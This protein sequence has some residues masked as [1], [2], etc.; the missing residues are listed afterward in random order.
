MLRQN[1]FG[2]Q[3]QEYPDPSIRDGVLNDGQYV[4]YVYRLHKVEFARLYGKAIA[5]RGLSVEQFMGGDYMDEGG[6]FDISEAVDDDDD[7]VQILEHWFRQP[8]DG[9]EK[10]ESFPAGAVACSIQANGK[11]LRY[12]PNYWKRT[13]KQCRLFPFIHYWRVQDENSF[14][15]KSE[16]FP[17]LN[18]IDAADRKMALNELNEVMS[19]NDMVIVEEEALADGEVLTNEPGATVTV[20]PNKI[21]AIRRLGGMQS[22]AS[23]VG[24]VEYYK[25]LME[26]A[27]RSYETTRGKE[28]ERTTTATGL[29]MIRADAE[30]QADIKLADRNYGFERLYELL[31]WLALEFFDDDRLIYL[32]ADRAGDHEE[33]VSLHF[34]SDALSDEMPEILDMQGKTVREAWRYWP[35]VDVTITAGDSVVKGK[36]ATLEA[37]QV[38]ST[39]TITADNWQLYAAQLEILD[40]PGKQEII[41]RWKQR[42]GMPTALPPKIEATGDTPGMA[43]Y[44]G[45]AP[46]N[47]V[48]STI[49]GIET[50]V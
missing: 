9:K 43:A 10:G 3:R 14:W 30:A 15:N 21:N 19:G 8:T 27:S 40:V 39:A 4:D 6:F 44:Q 2:K 45:A 32:G 20:K 7:T 42:F 25:S 24:T 22:I 38:L 46:E 29:A 41:E 49:N 36:Q 34:N 33:S 17:V 12:I 37:L 28:T 31:D 48:P 5:Q 1:A 11:E 26:R 35:D 50:M 13:C 18:I 47:A 23:G 16:L